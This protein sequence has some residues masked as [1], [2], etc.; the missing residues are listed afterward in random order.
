MALRRTHRPS[1]GEMRGRTKVRSE[2]LPNVFSPPDDVRMIKSRNRWVG[3]IADEKCAQ[4][5]G[6]KT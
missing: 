3:Y 2:G 6:S 1:R 5:F 4:N